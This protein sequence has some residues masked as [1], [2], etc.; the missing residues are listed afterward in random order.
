MF[1]WYLSFTLLSK[2]LIFIKQCVFQQ[3][4]FA[5]LIVKSSFC[6]CEH[7]LQTAEHLIY[8]CPIHLSKV[9]SHSTWSNQ[10]RN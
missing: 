5:P 3:N 9:D 4:D 1:I 8:Y 7:E 10:A 6:D 2:L